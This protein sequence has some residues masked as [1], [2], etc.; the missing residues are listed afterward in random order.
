MDAE[1]VTVADYP[2]Y[3]E[4]IAAKQV[5]RRLLA[6]RARPRAVRHLPASLRRL[7]RLDQRG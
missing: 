3:L 4:E 2:L 6:D 1:V 5:R 7:Q